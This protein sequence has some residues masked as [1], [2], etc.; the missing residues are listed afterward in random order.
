MTIRNVIQFED[1]NS[2]CNSICR[3]YCCG[4]KSSLHGKVMEILQKK[5]EELVEINKLTLNTN[6]TELILFSRSNSDFGSFF[7]L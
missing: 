6:K 1:D 2:K 7:V 4:Q 5:T 3:Q